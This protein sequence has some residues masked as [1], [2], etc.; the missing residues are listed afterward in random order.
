MIITRLVINGISNGG[1]ITIRIIYI[2]Y[3]C[4]EMGNSGG[5]LPR[6]EA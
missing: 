1:I 5:D 2:P 4:S 3:R 6:V